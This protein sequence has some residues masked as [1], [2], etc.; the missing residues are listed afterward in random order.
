MRLL[1]ARLIV[2]LILGITLVSSGFSYYEVLEEK[3]ALEDERKHWRGDASGFAIF[4]T[5]RR[6]NLPSPETVA[7]E[8]AAGFKRFPNYQ[9]SADELRQLKAEIYKALLRVV[10]GKRM[11]DLAEEILKSARP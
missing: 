2:S 11:V 3:R 10:S 5:L 4:W 7:G 6:E 8:I 1:S 9:T